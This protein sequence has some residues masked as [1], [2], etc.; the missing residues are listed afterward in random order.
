M[1][2][3]EPSG[4]RIT[5]SQSN[6][7]PAFKLALIVNPVAGLG[8]PAGLK[9]SDAPDTA[10]IARQRGV[11]A[12]AAERVADVLAGL[13]RLSGPI[14][15]LTVS[16]NM[17]AQLCEQMQMPHVVH[18]QANEMSTPE[19]TVAAARALQ[20]CQPDLLVFAGGDG[21][22]RD[23]CRAV[24]TA[25]PVLGIPA[26]VKMHSGVFCV[27]PRALVSVVESLLTHKL[28]ALTHAEV[29]DIDEA[30]FARGEVRTRHYGEL[31]VP[32]DQLLV[33]RVKCSGLPDDVLMLD[34]IAAYLCEEIEDDT[35]YVLGSGGTLMHIK[36]QLGVSQPTLLGVDLWCNGQTL[37]SD[38][39]EQQLFDLL[40]AYPN[41]RLLLSIIGGQGVVLGRGNQ[42]IS[43]RVIRQAGIE[44]IRFVATQEKIKALQGAPLR[45]DSGDDA[46]DRAL[47]G[48]HRVLCGYEDELLY[49][50]RYLD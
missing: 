4:N 47:S 45:V 38:V 29:R 5:L 18:Y 16:G 42:Q 10:D 49:E 23:I 9:G 33:Q 50:I 20:S 32:D 40:Q 14:E 12:R 8:G 46:L 25:L 27:T 7:P 21:T 1:T 3:C 48:F 30:A 39:H 28:V 19:D 26:G 35:L 13:K 37:A 36:Q 22:A 34:E 15:V 41:C 6:T 31:L 2:W 43:P 44:N 17:G 24:G 11:Q